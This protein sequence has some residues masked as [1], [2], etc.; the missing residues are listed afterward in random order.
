MVFVSQ[1]SNLKNNYMN[2]TK[3]LYCYINLQ[4]E[5]GLIIYWINFSLESIEKMMNVKIYKNG[6]YNKKIKCLVVNE[7]K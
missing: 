1:A 5:F 3:I 2:I 4:V 6:F 7:V